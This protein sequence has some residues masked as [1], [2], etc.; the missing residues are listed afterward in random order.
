[1]AHSTRCYFVDE[2]GDGTLFDKKGKVIIG[3]EGCS[4]FFV[5]GLLDASDPV[6]LDKDMREMREKLR[7][8]PY[9]R[10]VPSMQPSAK[11][12]AMAFHAKDDLPEIRRE[13]FSLLLKHDLR[14]FA[15]VRD[16]AK[17]LDYVR[18][19]NQVAPDYRYNPNELYDFLVRS[20]FRDRLHKEDEYIIY[21]AKRG[22][23]DRTE[24][25]S[26]ALESAR[27][28]FT[29]R[30]GIVSTA[31]I[32]AIPSVPAKASGLQ[33][34]DYFLWALQRFYER[35]EE[36]FLRLLWPRCRLVRD[37]DDVRNNQYGEYYTRKKPLTLAAFASSPGI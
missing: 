27:R 1:M 23:S 5:L 32:R 6:A 20:L 35:K 26:L 24:A 8:D 4:R 22:K 3:K 21:F 9:F 18:Q 10:D 25:L 34:A 16:K 11:K 15:V 13:V 29:E 17:V 30:W 12:T 33:A 19:R 2:A 37:L 14:F 31:S 36:R 28:R 7:A